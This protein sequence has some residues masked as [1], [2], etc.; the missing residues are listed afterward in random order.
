MLWQP[1][2]REK[3]AFGF[4]SSI[5]YYCLTDSQT[6]CKDGGRPGKQSDFLQIIE[7]LGLGDKLDKYPSELSQGEQRVSIAR[8]LAKKPEI[9]FLDEPTGLDEETGA[10]SRSYLVTEGKLGFTSSWWR[11]TKNIAIWPE[12]S[13]ESIVA[14][15]G[16]R[17]R[18]KTRC[19]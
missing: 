17:K 18:T 9:L 10:D 5:I 19:A 16:A 3:I 6:E 11:T 12:P 4:S 8:A 2:R 15:A 13:F 1:F 7:D 14:E